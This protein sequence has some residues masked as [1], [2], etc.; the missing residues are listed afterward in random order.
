MIVGLDIGTTSAI[1]VYDLKRNLLYLKSRRH[2]STSNIIKQIMIFGTPIIIATDKQNVPDKIRKIAASFGA[3]IFSPDHDLTIEEKDKIVNIS[4]KDSHERDAL[5][6][7]LFAFRFYHPQFITI[8]MNLQSVGLQNQSDRVKEMI[9]RKEAKNIAEA[10]DKLRPKEK[11]KEIIQPKFVKIDYEERAMV[12]EKK[13][14]DERQSHE[15]LKEYSDK[16]ETR[17]RNL[18]IQK[19]EYLEEQ[20]KKNEDTRRQIM[21]DKEIRNRD[22]MV[23]QLKFQLEKE[24][25]IKNAYEEK[26]KID[27]ELKDIKS[28]K[29]IPVILIPSF[30]KEDVLDAHRKYNISDKAVWIQDFR[31]S[32]VAA[33]V[34]ASIRPKLVFGETDKETRDVLHNSGIIV[35]DTIKPEMRNHYAAVS[36]QSIE[37]EIKKIEKKSF[38]RWLED[39]KHRY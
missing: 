21:K 2:W 29:K 25:S 33:K 20:M 30:S 12:L 11:E 8:D 4:M 19:Q 22:I 5:A 39:Y 1:S 18:Q 23:R 3:H 15:I 38:L 36:P 6:S 14:K 26:G 17:V 7:S 32:K 16:L 10:I 34:L 35:V 13:L 27:Q 37:S 9:I 28:E 31:L 24:K